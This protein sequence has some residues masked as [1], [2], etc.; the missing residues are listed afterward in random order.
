MIENLLYFL[1]AMDPIETAPKVED[2][3]LLIIQSGRRFIAEWDDG[4][5]YFFAI[6]ALDGIET[7]KYHQEF[8]GRLYFPE[9]WSYIDVIL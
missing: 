7:E 3:P 5:G 1:D 8:P 9:F 2:S 4:S 6:V